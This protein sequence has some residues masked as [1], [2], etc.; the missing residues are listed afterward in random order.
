MKAIV[1]PVKE[2][3]EAKQRLAAHFSSEDRALL[4]QAM[5]ED[6]LRVVSEVQGVERVFVISKEPWALS[7]ARAL[8]WETIVES[9]QTSESHSVD[10]ASQYCT[11]R[12]IRALLRVPIDVP[13]TEPEDIEA[14]FEQLDGQTDAVIVPSSSG[15]GTNAILR[16][17]PGLFPSRFGPNSFSLHQAEAD[18][19]G[20]RMRVLRNPRLELDIDE[21]EDLRNV[22]AR[23]PPDSATSRWFIAKGLR[24]AVPG[25]ASR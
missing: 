5:C 18:R 11:S 21:L 12:G 10:A 17:P 2:F 25:S 22:A 19:C 13:L 16:S 14:V 7:K 24:S 4:A 9:H 20:A 8:G 6:L 15:T 3:R 23:L 1:I